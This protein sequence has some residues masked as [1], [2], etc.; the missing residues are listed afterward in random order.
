MT[1]CGARCRASLARRLLGLLACVV[2]GA[3]ALAGTA[4]AATAPAAAAGFADDPIRVRDAQM[5]ISDS[6]SEPPA[7]AA[8]E[9]V[10]LPHRVRK[11]GGNALVGYWYKTTFTLP[12]APPGADP[13]SYNESLWLLFAQLPSGGTVFLNG[14]EVGSIPYADPATQVRWHRPHMVFLPSLSLR[15]GTNDLAV[16]FAIRELLTSFGGIEVGPERLIRPRFVHANFVESISSDISSAIC[17]LAGILMIAFWLRRP[18]ERL[19]GLFG[20]CVLFWGLRTLFLQIPIV[21]MSALPWWRSLYYFTTGGFIVLITMFMLKFGEYERRWIRRV[22]F[23]YWLGGSIAFTLI[24]MP[25]RALMDEFWIPGFLP[26]ALFGIAR[27]SLYVLRYRTRTSIAM[28]SAIFIVLGLAIHDYVVQAGWFHL[29]E[30]YIL[31]LGIPWFLLVMA[32]VLSDRFLDSLKKVESVNEQLA[33][34]VAQREA[35]LAMSYERLSRLER[36]HGASEERQRIMQDMHD[37]VG[38]QLLTTIAVVERGVANRS[39]TLALLQECLDDMRLAIDSLSPNDPDLLPA[40]GSFRF[41]M[42]GRFRAAGITLTWCNHGMPDSLTLGAHAGLHVLRI[43]QE[44]LA[45]IIKHAKA[46]T[47]VVDVHFLPGLLHVRIADD[48]V[49]FCATESDKRLE[50]SRGLRNMQARAQ[51]IGAAFFIE[52]LATGTALHLK[53]P[54]DASAEPALAA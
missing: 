47:T 12:P 4:P 25:M 37:G 51:K 16:H 8:W 15:T 14:A 10:R 31:H 26:L 45:N 32:G 42:E 40:I 9:S 19:Y 30:V 21:P 2:L 44:A 48:G 46:T 52:H 49:G 5:I 11:P 6:A 22:L 23:T 13:D 38:S 29:E 1:I 43:L 7:N 36:A 53:I 3:P 50:N 33:A 34:R 17:L 27:L 28:G 18:Q 35:E 54:T 39:Y 20:V 41:R 24:G